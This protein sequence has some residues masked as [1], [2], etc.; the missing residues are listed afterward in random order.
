VFKSWVLKRISGP[1]I[2]ELTGGWRKLHNEELHNL[3]YSY[4]LLEQTN[5]E[6]QDGQVM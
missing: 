3:R 6:G 1:K 5:Q 4:I 2:E